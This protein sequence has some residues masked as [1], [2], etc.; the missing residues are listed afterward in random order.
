[1]PGYVDC[2]RGGPTRSGANGEDSIARL[3]GCEEL[4]SFRTMSAGCSVD[5][6]KVEYWDKPVRP[7]G[8]NVVRRPLLESRGDERK[9]WRI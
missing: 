1:M 9:G 2:A 5:F 7:I 3:G 8:L 6:A 4:G